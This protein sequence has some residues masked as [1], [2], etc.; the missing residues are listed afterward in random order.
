MPLPSA[1][2]LALL[3]PR[4]RARMCP[5]TLPPVCAYNVLDHVLVPVA[6]ETCMSRHSVYAS[7]QLAIEKAA[8]NIQ[9][10]ITKSKY[11]MLK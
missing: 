5:L 2:S 7:L 1:T 6:H 8:K 10:I 3:G 9:G 4:T 11:S